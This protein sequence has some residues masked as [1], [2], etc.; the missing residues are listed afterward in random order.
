MG[1]TDDELAPRKSSG[2]KAQQELSPVDL[3]LTQGNTDSKDGTLAIK[4]NAESDQNGAVQELA[5]PSVPFHSGHP[6]SSMG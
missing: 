1:I 2:L 3:G 6:A 5:T 4:A